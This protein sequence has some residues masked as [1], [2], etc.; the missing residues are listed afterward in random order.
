MR[1]IA[2][3]FFK[4]FNFCNQDRALHTSCTGSQDIQTSQ[5]SERFC[6][7]LQLNTENTKRAMNCQFMIYDFL[8]REKTKQERIKEN[9]SLKINLF[10]SASLEVIS[11]VLNTANFGGFL[12]C[13][14][15]DTGHSVAFGKSL[16]SIYGHPR[17]SQKFPGLCVSV[18]FFLWAIPPSHHMLNIKKLFVLSAEQRSKPLFSWDKPDIIKAV[19]LF[20]VL[21][22]LCLFT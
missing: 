14:V 4:S 17:S 22:R 9:K 3:V 10:C 1:K 7:S 19:N 15:F 8:K 5:G 21:V 16:R 12:T 20:P 2:S 13:K 18:C 11:P 6:C